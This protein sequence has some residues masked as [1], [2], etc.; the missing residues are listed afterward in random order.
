[1]ITLCFAACALGVHDASSE[2]VRGGPN[3]DE[4]WCAEVILLMFKSPS[5]ACRKPSLASV[6]RA[7]EPRDDDRTILVDGRELSSAILSCKC[8][9][10][11]CEA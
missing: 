9:I 3:D 8:G 2:T 11:I 6:I 1:M 4:D 7:S 10:L 5:V